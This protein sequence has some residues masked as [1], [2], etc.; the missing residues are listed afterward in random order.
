M[1]LSKLRINYVFGLVGIS[2]CLAAAHGSTALSTGKT[3]PFLEFQKVLKISSPAMSPDAK[4]VAYLS[5]ESGYSSLYID[6]IPPSHSQKIIDISGPIKSFGWSPTGAS[7]VYQSDSDGDENYQIVLFDLTTK[8]SK[9]ITKN[10]KRRYHFCGFSDDGSLISY[11]TNERDERFFDI[12]AMTGT[13]AGTP[14]LLVRSDKTNTCG[15]GFSPDNTRYSFT[16]FHENNHQDV[17]VLDL[18]SGVVKELTPPDDRGKNLSLGWSQDGLFH[19][20]LSDSSSE[21]LRLIRTELSSGAKSVVFDHNWDIVDAGWSKKRDSSYYVTNE[22][23]TSI[24][25]LFKGEFNSRVK[26]QIPSGVLGIGNFS[27]DGSKFVYTLSNGTTPTSLFVYDISS[28]QSKMLV[29]S[30]R[31]SITKD[32]FVDGKQVTIRSFD[33]LEVP[34]YLYLPH[35]ATKDAKVPGIV[36]VHGGPEDQE[37]NNYNGRKQFLVNQGFALIVPNVR[38]STGYG[39]SYMMKDNLDWGGGHIRDLMAASRSLKAHEAVDSRRV[40]ILGG[41]FGGFSVL[42]AVTQFPSEFA[43]AIDIFG[44]SNLVTFV[45]SVPSHWRAWVYSE[46]GH[47]A[48]DLDLLRFRSPINH[49]ANI[50]TPLLVIQGANDPRVVKRESDQIVAKLKALKR[51]VEYLVFDDEG[52]GF[53][54]SVNEQSAFEAM[55][56]FLNSRLK[57]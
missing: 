19:F 4:Q 43:A 50:R 20:S 33:G 48:H 16:V 28:G 12:Y 57:R 32:Q 14:Q 9:T 39:K 41:S 22:N 2:C 18:A 17:Q 49:V 6:T 47:P 40:A 10:L 35:G 45:D 26:A 29:D 34:A 44:P 37:L 27:A 7:L 8:K 11:S 15:G 52:H 38:G 55:A 13:G 3:Y 21:F 24:L 1:R 30:N 54:R 31:S 42:S 5:N 53:S 25:H 56:G 51:P 46:A 23:G 36:W